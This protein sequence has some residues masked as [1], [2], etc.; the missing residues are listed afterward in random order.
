[1]KKLLKW[2][3]P[4]IGQFPYASFPNYADMRWTYFLLWPGEWRLDLDEL[5]SDGNIIF[6]VIDHMSLAREAKALAEFLTRLY[7]E[8]N[9]D[10][11]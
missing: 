5:S 1:M 7:L 8:E 6:H 11:P 3:R 9:D 2:K 4:L 10:R